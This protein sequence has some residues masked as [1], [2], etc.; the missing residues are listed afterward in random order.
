MP[1][2]TYRCT[3]CAVVCTVRHGMRDVLVDCASCD[4]P[5]VLVRVPTD[6]SLQK[7]DD[8]HGQKPGTLVKKFIE[9]TREQIKSKKEETSGSRPES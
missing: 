9:D 7:E 3:A 5:G 2:Y 4:A 1:K 6:I 8:H